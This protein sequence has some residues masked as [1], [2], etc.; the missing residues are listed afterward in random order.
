M[1]D[2]DVIDI[3]VNEKTLVSNKSIT[4]S[5]E[6]IKVKL[7]EGENWIGVKAINEGTN[8]PASPHIEIYDGKTTQAF[9]ILAY[10]NQPGGYKIKV[11]L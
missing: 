11:N 7:S 10:I 2:G 8:P 1:L 5:K 3:L 6:T 9:D 4:E